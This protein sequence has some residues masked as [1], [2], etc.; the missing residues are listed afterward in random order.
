MGGSG[1]DPITELKGGADDPG[2][3]DTGIAGRRRSRLMP[4]L[5]ALAILAGLYA[6]L[7]RFGA[8]EGLSDGQA[9]REWIEGLGIFGPLTVVALLAGAIVLN[10]IP[11]APIALASGAAYGHVWGTVYV[12][13]GAET[14]ALIAFTIARVAGHD[15]LTRWL[16]RRPSLGA[17][18]SQNTLMAVV[19]FSRLLPFVSFD[20]ISYAAGLTPLTF[21][22]F[23]VATLAGIVPASFL[24]A[25]FGGEMASENAGRA[26]AAVLALGV[27]TIAPIL[28][29]LMIDRRKAKRR[30]PTGRKS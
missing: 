6:L 29:K 25:H 26:I 28:V 4:A 20:L 21:W 16:G 1:E 11:S 13:V 18:T 17:L 8:L 23:A 9:L 24:L 2:S 12:V 7:W 10:P 27:V 30:L 15:M 3:P 14:G 19:F 5:A 22:R